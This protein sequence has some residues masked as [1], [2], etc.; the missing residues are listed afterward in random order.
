[1]SAA[2]KE[3][4]SR[5]GDYMRSGGEKGEAIEGKIC[6]SEKI[7]LPRATNTIKIG[8]LCILVRYQYPFP[9]PKITLFH[10]FAKFDYDS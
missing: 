1:M 4:G 8:R 5:R 2:V 3:V 6:V 9:L 7:M 10:L